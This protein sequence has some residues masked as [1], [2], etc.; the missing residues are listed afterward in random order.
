MCTAHLNIPGGCWSFDGRSLHIF[1]FGGMDG[2]PATG[3]LGNPYTLNLPS[4]LVHTYDLEQWTSESNMR[5]EVVG[6]TGP[7]DPT[8]LLTPVPF[9]AHYLSPL[10]T[11]GAAH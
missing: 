11:S 4:F 3:I 1:K 5:G 6:R 7:V 2:G 9:P 8:R 10:L